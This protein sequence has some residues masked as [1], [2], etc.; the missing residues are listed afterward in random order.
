MRTFGF[1]KLTSQEKA[2]QFAINNNNETSSSSSSTINTTSIANFNQTNNESSFTRQ[3][4]NDFETANFQSLL[5]VAANINDTNNSNNNNNNN[6]NDTNGTNSDDSSS[7]NNQNNNN[8]GGAAARE[9]RSFQ[10]RFAS[11]DVHEVFKFSQL[12][13]NINFYFFIIYLGQSKNIFYFIE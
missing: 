12:K 10:R 5:I 11:N 1:N 6:N 4:S 3:R 13:V 8:S 7:N 9:A 2:K